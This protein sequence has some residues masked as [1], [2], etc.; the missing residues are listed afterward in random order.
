MRAFKEYLA[1]YEEHAGALRANPKDPLALLMLDGFDPKVVKKFQGIRDRV[2]FFAEDL[3]KR[4]GA[5]FSLITQELLS[6]KRWKTHGQ[7]IKYAD[8]IQIGL[9]IEYLPA[10][11]ER[12]EGYW[13][14]YCLQRIEVGEDKKIFESSY[15]SQAF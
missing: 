5:N 14:L 7:P 2:Q 8:A 13:R 10:S 6:S 1:A 4:Q 15:V 12:W 11:D 3:L 9:P